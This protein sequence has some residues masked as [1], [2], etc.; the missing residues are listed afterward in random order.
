LITDCSRDLLIF[1]F[2]PI[3][4]ELGIRSKFRKLKSN[5]LTLR[6]VAKEFIQQI[7]TKMALAD[8]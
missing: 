4:Y 5:I 6:T 8:Q 2:G 7:N 1:I 3:A